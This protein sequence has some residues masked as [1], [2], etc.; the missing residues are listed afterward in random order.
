V[1]DILINCGPGANPA[2]Y[3]QLTIAAPTIASGSVVDANSAV[4]SGVALST[5]V[6]FPVE[7][8]TDGA[9]AFSEVPDDV[10][11][12]YLGTAT[13]ATAS[14]IRVAGLSAGSY[15]IRAF[16]SSDSASTRVGSMSVNGRTAV[17]YDCMN[18]GTFASHCATDTVTLNGSEN[19]DLSFVRVS[20]RGYVN[21]IRITPPVAAT[22]LSVDG[23]NSVA[24]GQQD[25]VINVSGIPSGNVPVRAGAGGTAGVGGTD[26][27]GLSVVAGTTAG[28]YAITCDVPVGIPTSSSA[29]CYVEYSPE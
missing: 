11:N 23:D 18:G 9:V 8:S 25:I 17:N 29:Q 24:Q 2:G 22:V 12:S 7:S 21:E 3:N 5:P 28:V 6:A 26:F 4:V 19:L 1:A 27:T 20:T 16:G 10:E 15:T 14:T 13:A